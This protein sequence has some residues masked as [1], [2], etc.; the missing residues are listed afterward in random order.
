[1][2][3]FCLMAAGCGRFGQVNQGRTVA[4]DKTAGA[5]TIVDGQGVVRTVRVPEDPREMGPAPEPGP[6]VRLDRE[7]GV[8]TIFE[9]GALRDVPLPAGGAVS[10]KFG[11]EVRYYY[12]DPGQALRLMNVT[13]TDLTKGK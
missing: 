6:L 2:L 8:A 13:K 12:K 7:R 11:D 5:L 10:W 9:A 4:F 3:V 1:M